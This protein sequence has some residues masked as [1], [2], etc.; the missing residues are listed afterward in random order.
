V[1]GYFITLGV[2][3]KLLNQTITGNGNVN[4]PI[5]PSSTRRAYWGVRPTELLVIQIHLVIR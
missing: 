1:I 5:N 3:F 2:L 4:K